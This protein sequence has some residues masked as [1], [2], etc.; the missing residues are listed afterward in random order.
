MRREAFIV[1]PTRRDRLWQ[2]DFS[3]FETAGAGTWNLGGVVDYWA[4]VN[5][6][7]TVTVTKTTEDAIAF[8]EAA[9]AE[10]EVLLGVTWTEDP[11]DSGSVLSP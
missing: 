8:F 7:C 4:E 9:P 10:V 3:E 5:L 11:T 6:A 2:A 1:P